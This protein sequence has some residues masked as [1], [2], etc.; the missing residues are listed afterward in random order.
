MLMSLMVTVFSSIVAQITDKVSL[1]VNR[2]TGFTE[3][4]NGLAGIVIPGSKA[5]AAKE[6]HLAPIQSFIYSNGLYSDNTA[7]YLV[8]ASR[9][10]S[11]EIK[12][13]R[14]STEEVAVQ[15][16]YKF[17]KKNLSLASLDTKA[18]NRD[19]VFILA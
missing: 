4:R 7:N 3:I 17:Q 9:P 1:T 6:Y 8:T 14:Q 2:A 19:L 5:I 18:V 11:L 13:L 15:F 10:L 12:I 16:L